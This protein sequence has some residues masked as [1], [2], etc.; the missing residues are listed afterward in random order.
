[1]QSWP[2]SFLM[3]PWS[4][5]VILDPLEFAGCNTQQSASIAQLGTCV[6]TLLDMS[7]V[8]GSVVGLAA[9]HKRLSAAGWHDMLCPHMNTLPDDSVSHLHGSCSYVTIMSFTAAVCMPARRDCGCRHKISS[10]CRSSVGTGKRVSLGNGGICPRLQ[11][12]PLGATWQGF[13]CTWPSCT[14][15]K[16]TL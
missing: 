12:L 4:C 16:C 5:H 1:M 3:H 2:W 6:L 10:K 7:L 9:L 11:Q 15:M 14:I 8:L 13:P